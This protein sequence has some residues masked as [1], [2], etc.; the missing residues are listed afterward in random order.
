M[1]FTKICQVVFAL[2]HAHGQTEECRE[3][4]RLIVAFRNCFANTLKRKQ[5][6]EE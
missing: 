2:S 1:N 4:T 5:N 6:H 3:A